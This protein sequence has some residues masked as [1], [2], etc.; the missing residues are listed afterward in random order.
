MGGQNGIY[1]KG[2]HGLHQ[3]VP[4]GDAGYHLSTC[5]KFLSKIN[6]NIGFLSRHSM[7]NLPMHTTAVYH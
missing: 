5:R 4:R 2:S 7:H 1:G 6:I 3:S